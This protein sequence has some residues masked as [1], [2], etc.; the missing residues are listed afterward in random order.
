M[1]TFLKHIGIGIISA[2]TAFT[3]A[4]HS[5]SITPPI[6]NSITTEISTTT[7]ITISTTTQDSVATSTIKNSEPKS[8]PVVSK[9]TQPTKTLNV[10]Q[11]TNT[12]PVSSTPVV[13]EN[14]L[15]KNL[16]KEYTDFK[17]QIS[18]KISNIDIDSSLPSQQQ[19]RS[20]LISLLNSINAD[21]G[22][23]ETVESW[24]PRPANITG[25]YT[26]KFNNLKSQ[27][28]TEN[29]QYLSGI[30]QDNL[31]ATAANE[32]A[33]ENA[34]LAKQNYVKEIN[35]KI[36]EMD[37]LSVQI[38]TLAGTSLTDILNNAKKLDGSTLFYSFQIP[39]G[40][41]TAIF[42]YPYSLKGYNNNPSADMI[43]GFQAIVANYRAYLN[44]EL[45]KNQ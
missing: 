31:N 21:L 23:L 14:D 15:Y 10:T 16:I 17:S 5:Q 4:F 18:Y 13:N 20:N 8:K 12:N 37:Q 41:G 26:T 7:S 40:Y 9:K 30:K 33:I 27:Y 43:K 45:V 36:A 25:M 22:Y 19:Y 28:S 34:N 2:F 38:N 32:Q 42:P 3:G 24:N 6:Q 11:I 44:V 29:S 39:S 35:V 1:F